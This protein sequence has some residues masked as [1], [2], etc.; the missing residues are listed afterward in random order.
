[1][2]PRSKAP[3]RQIE[4]AFAGIFGST[5]VGLSGSY[6]TPIQ[7]A[8]R[9]CMIKAVNWIASRSAGKFAVET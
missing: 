4:G 2:P 5:L 3:P 7:N 1:M 9:A 8:L 6:K